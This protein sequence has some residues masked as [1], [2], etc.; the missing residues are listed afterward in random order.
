M[1]RVGRRVVG[2]AAVAMAM[3]KQQ[4]REHLNS[5]LQE[6]ADNTYEANLTALMEGHLGEID[7]PMLL[8]KRLKSAKRVLKFMQNNEV[9]ISIKSLEQEC[10]VKH[11]RS[12][13]ANRFLG[14]LVFFLLFSLAM[15]GQRNGIRSEQ[16]TR[17]LLNYF[18]ESRY[19]A[20]TSGSV[21]PHM[22]ASGDNCTNHLG[23]SAAGGCHIPP[24]E[25]KNFMDIVT[26]EDFWDWTSLSLVERFYQQEWENGQEMTDQETNT[27]MRRIRPISGLR[28]VQRRASPGVETQDRFNGGCWHYNSGAMRQFASECYDELGFCLDGT[29]VFGAED[30][31]PY[32]TFSNSTKYY[33]QSF[34][35]GSSKTLY[36]DEEGFF[37]FFPHASK[38]AKLE[39]QLLID[40]L[41]ADRWIDKASQW[42]RFDFIA[43]NPDERIL[44]LARFMLHFENSGLTIPIVMIDPFQ[45]NFYDFSQRLDV[46]RA[47]AEFGTVVAW[48]FNVWAQIGEVLHYRSKHPGISLFTAWWRNLGSEFHSI[49]LDFQLILMP[50]LF[51]LWAFVTVD[52]YAGGLDINSNHVD[53]DGVPIFLSSLAVYSRSYFILCGLMMLLFVFRVIAMAKVN[54]RFSLLSESIDQMK[55]RLFNFAFVLVLFQIMFTNTAVV[56]FGDKMA[57]FAEWQDAFVTVTMLLLGAG[58]T[59][60][61]RGAR[62]GGGEGAVSSVDYPDLYAASP[63]SA[64]IWYYPFFAVMV[65]VVINITIAIIGESYARVKSQRS[66]DNAECTLTPS[67]AL[68]GEPTSVWHQVSRGASQR[69]RWVHGCT[70]GW[71]GA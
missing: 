64:F 28:L 27:W 13:R 25:M 68:L 15:V 69:F 24:A 43:L 65:L 30:K 7:G 47:V 38:N 50:I 48:A 21:W 12:K 51:I 31:K 54:P 52:P 57:S 55:G 33:Y 11:E 26:L 18:L 49:I 56:M 66:V 1:P 29:C 53:W 19:Y 32:G 40:M 59:G 34:P 45:V 16:L 36:H 3:K 62:R 9:T 63:T 61:K 39:A 17:T 6:T 4:T 10:T 58:G 46:L 70:A 2:R 22:G 20:P 23:L 42:V 44:W 71:A 41:K 60:K 5:L 14:F 67:E 35:T 8:Q 37:V